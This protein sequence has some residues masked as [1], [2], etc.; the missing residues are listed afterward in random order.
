MGAL[1]RAHR[2]RL[3]VLS[4][5]SRPPPVLGDQA[6]AIFVADP[7]EAGGVARH[8]TLVETVGP[9]SAMGVCHNSSKFSPARAPPAV[10]LP[11]QEDALGAP[12]GLIELAVSDAGT[13]PFEKLQLV[14][15]PAKPEAGRVRGVLDYPGPAQR[16]ART[17]GL[18]GDLEG[19]TRVS[20]RRGRPRSP[21]APAPS[22]PWCSARSVGCHQCQ[23]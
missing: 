21:R 3:P 13:V 23:S 8:Y 6:A 22:T 20:C 16:G 15:E 19:R 5:P 1:R 12:F 18:Y 2:R 11:T 4:Q 10:S 9:T 7:G 17:L 14:S